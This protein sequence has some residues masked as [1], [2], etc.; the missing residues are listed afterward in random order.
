MKTKKKFNRYIITL[1]LTTVFGG[2]IGFINYLFNIF[3]ARFTN[4]HIFALYSAAIGII[5][6]IQTPAISIQNILTKVVGENEKVDFKVLKVKS[7]L[8]FSGIGTALSIIFFFFI[9]VI[10][11][12]EMLSSQLYVPLA[13]TLL[14]SFITTIPKGI[15]LG[16]E[17]VVLV[18]F[19]LLGETLLRFLIGYIG[20]KMGG[21]IYLLILANS[22]PAFLTLLII[23]PFLKSP[24]THKKKVKIP[25]KHLTLMITSLLLLSVP[26]TLDLVLTP[27]LY[28]AEYG[29]LS[30]IGKIVYFACTT[31][32]FVMFS[33]LSNQKNEK[34]ELKTLGATVLMTFLIG[35]VMTAGIYLFRGLLIDFAFGG[36]YSDISIYFVVFGVLM[37]AYAIV[38]MMANY[39]FSRDSYWYILILLLV[40]ILQVFLFNF[41]IDSISTIVR[42]Q[43]IVYSSL[44][45]L[46]FIYFIFNFLLKRDDKVVKENI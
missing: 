22:L 23:T 26:Y 33:K 27:Q 29:A 1:L 31:I 20:V 38:F 3:I 6:L 13:I 34:E 25:Y 8:V 30:L 24:E 32:A 35:I 41:N 46:T 21:N 37:T 45:I 14:L 9:P 15:L 11:T 18:N 44:L 16:K 28:K 5:Y 36:K 40:A 12:P 42:N 17:R 19:I 2:V 43:V 39:F 7:F 4:E 10:T